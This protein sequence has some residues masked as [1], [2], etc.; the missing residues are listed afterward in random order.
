VVV[1]TAIKRGRPIRRPK[2][3]E[4]RPRRALISK[5]FACHD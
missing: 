1:V 2:S 5:Q 4:E 3:R